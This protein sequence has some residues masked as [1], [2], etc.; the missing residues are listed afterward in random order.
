MSAIYDGQGA[1]ISCDG[2]N[3]AWTPQ[4]LSCRLPAPMREQ[5]RTSHLGSSGSATCVAGRLGSYEPIEVQF[6]ADF[7]D[8]PLVGRAQETIRITVGDYSI[9]C[10]GFCSR[11]LPG[12]L[13]STAP[14]VS[15]ATFVVSGDWALVQSDPL[16]TWHDTITA[17][18]MIQLTWELADGSGQFT[19]RYYDAAPPVAYVASN[20]P[21]W[22]STDTHEL[23]GGQ[24]LS[25]PAFAAFHAMKR[26]TGNPPLLVAVTIDPLVAPAGVYRFD[27]H[28]SQASWY[29]DAV[30][31]AAS[32][33]QPSPLAILNKWV[34][35]RPLIIPDQD[36]FSRLYI[37]TDGTGRIGTSYGYTAP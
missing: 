15:T 14:A 34:P 12:T 31:A 19:L 27:M 25:G 35:T 30:V 11:Y 33:P 36:Q 7:D 16:V 20:W 22:G 21:N 9:T 28:G 5:I 8:P 6:F 10:S 2:A 23:T 18:E 17:G 24:W 29:A 26:L 3:S 37:W 32:D 4:L 1:S 13:S